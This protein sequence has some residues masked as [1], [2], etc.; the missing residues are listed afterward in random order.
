[1]RAVRAGFAWK[2]NREVLNPAVWLPPVIVA[3]VGTAIV[4]WMALRMARGTRLLSG[5]PLPFEMECSEC[6]KAMV[7]A[8]EQVRELSPSER[9]LVVRDYPHVAG[10]PLGEYLCPHCQAAH[11]FAT[12]TPVLEW[13][14]ANCYSPQTKTGRCLEC[15]KMLRTPPWPRG[16]YDGRLRDAPRMEPD[17][18]LQCPYCK[19]VVCI[20]CAERVG[21]GRDQDAAYTCPRCR[22]KPISTMYHG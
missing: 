10:R 8:V 12:D 3:A 21:H 22:R 1:M 6:C 7:V 17:Y 19:S 15:R 20:A 2:G 9:G 13:I 18:G 11:C 4:A 16:A 5:K 14:A